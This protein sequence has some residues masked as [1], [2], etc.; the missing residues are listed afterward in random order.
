VIDVRR[1]VICFVV[2][3]GCGGGRDA[4]DAPAVAD[5]PPVVDAPKDVSGGCEL[6]TIFVMAAD[7]SGATQLTT[8]T[9][10]DGVWR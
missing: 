2:G 4:A 10:E 7:G 9:A 8:N 1:G 3:A 5:G 6:Y